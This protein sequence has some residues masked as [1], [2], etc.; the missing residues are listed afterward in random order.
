M[1]QALKPTSGAAWAQVVATEL[2]NSTSPWTKR[3][4]RLTWVSEGNDFRRLRVTLKAGEV[5]EIAMFAHDTP[6]SMQ[7]AACRRAA[8]Y[9]ISHKLQP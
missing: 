8:C 7:D 4:P 5:F 6:P 1:Q 9:H 3:R 2:I